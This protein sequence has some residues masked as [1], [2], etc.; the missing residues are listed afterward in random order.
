MPKDLKAKGICIGIAALIAAAI[1]V[2]TSA[3]LAPASAQQCGSD[4]KRAEAQACIRDCGHK[5]PKT[6]KSD[7]SKRM[8]CQDTCIAKC[9]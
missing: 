5:F 8:A 1:V 4:K 7:R 3:V 9:K 6:E 2:S